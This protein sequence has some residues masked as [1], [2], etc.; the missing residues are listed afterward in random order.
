GGYFFAETQYGET[1]QLEK[2]RSAIKNKEH[3]ILEDLLTAENITADYYEK[4]TTYFNENPEQLDQ[5][6]SELETEMTENKDAAYFIEVL[7]TEKLLFLFPQY[8]YAIQPVTVNASA[9]FEK[10]IITISDLETYEIE[11]P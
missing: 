6:I 10:T 5:F 3:V 1:A 8:H 4:F 9:N 2:L 7:E 11:E